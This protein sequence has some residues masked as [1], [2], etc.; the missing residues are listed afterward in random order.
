MLSNVKA[1]TGGKKDNER[2]SYTLD[3]RRVRIGMYLS[4]KA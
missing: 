4:F 1:S 3:G 2:V